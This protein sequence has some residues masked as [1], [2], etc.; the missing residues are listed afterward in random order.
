MTRWLD[1]IQSGA[2]TMSQRKLSSIE[3]HGGIE[4]AIAAAKQRGVHLVKLTDDKG[5]ALV[6]ASRHPFQPLC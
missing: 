3:A 6:A 1:A 5:T 2:A 4:Q